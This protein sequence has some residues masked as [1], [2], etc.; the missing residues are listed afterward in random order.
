MLYKNE[1]AWSSQKLI[2]LAMIKEKTD[3]LKKEIQLKMKND[4]KD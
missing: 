3:K 2:V 4:K 1:N